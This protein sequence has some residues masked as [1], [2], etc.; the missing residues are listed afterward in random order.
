[1]IKQ[2]LI[3]MDVCCFNR[4][5]DDWTQPRIRLKAEAILT[6]IEPCQVD[7]WKLITSTALESEIDQTPD[8]LRRQQVMDSLRLAQAKI[9]V[10]P[11]I[12]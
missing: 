8:P 5:F 10:T 2:Y 9:L 1:M 12:I 7:L 6:I 3:Y 11:E 4:L